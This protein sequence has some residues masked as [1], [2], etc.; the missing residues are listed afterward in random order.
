LQESICKPQSVLC[1]LP[2][3]YQVEAAKAGEGKQLLKVLFVTKAR[4]EGEISKLDVRARLDDYLY[5]LGGYVG[6]AHVDSLHV[7]A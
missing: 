6:A 7:A 5:P 2:C 4:T 1:E 3:S